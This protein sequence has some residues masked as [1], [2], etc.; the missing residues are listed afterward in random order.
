MSSL[1]VSD[2]PSSSSHFVSVN[3]LYAM[4]IFLLF[5]FTSGCVTDTPS[6]SMEEN[7]MGRL[8]CDSTELDFDTV[9]GF[10]IKGTVWDC[11]S[12]LNGNTEKPVIIA[13]HQFA[14]DRFDYQSFAEYASQHYSYRVYAFDLRGF[15]E[16][17]QK[18][19]HSVDASSFTDDDFKKIAKDITQAK[20]IL[21]AETIFVIGA[22]IGAN[23]ALNY[24]AS[25][26][27]TK[28]IVLLSPGLNYKGIDV[29]ESMSFS[30]VPM[31]IMA[32]KG[33]AYSFNSSQTIFSSS[34][35]T[36]KQL[37][38][39]E[40]KSHGTQLFDSSIQSPEIVFEEILSWLDLHAK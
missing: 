27:E 28:G 24:S 17:T 6:Q 19:G 30:T 37:V 13:L 1:V 38:L 4:V 34:P 22:S 32:S 23:S 9:D 15:G 11:P 18:I 40:G 25:H 16:S 21:N 31:L 35:L 29:K 12:S 7:A 14:S 26:P 8:Q 39:K 36:D 2:S 10:R 5:L 33:D 20:K 3:L